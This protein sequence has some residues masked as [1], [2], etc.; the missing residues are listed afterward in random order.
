M[1]RMSDQRVLAKTKMH[2]FLMGKIGLHECRHLKKNAFLNIKK[3]HSACVA[4]A[5]SFRSV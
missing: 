3:L 4:D 1:V 5:A 2:R